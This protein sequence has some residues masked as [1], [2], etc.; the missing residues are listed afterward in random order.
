MIWSNMQTP[1]EM[2]SVAKKQAIACVCNDTTNVS[3]T[4]KS[5]CI[6]ISNQVINGLKMPNIQAK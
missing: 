6:I 1:S 4:L 2:N 5:F 3:F